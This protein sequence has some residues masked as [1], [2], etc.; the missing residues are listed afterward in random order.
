MSSSTW[1]QVLGGVAAGIALS[2]AA[3]ALAQLRPLVAPPASA[4]A[5][6]AGVEVFVL[7]ESR[8]AQPAVGPAEIETVALDGTK[9]RLIA[10]TD[11]PQ[12]VAPGGFARLHYRLAV[13]Y[14]VAAAQA[15][16]EQS[17]SAPLAARPATAETVVATSRGGS[18]AFLDR[19]YPYAPIYGVAGVGTAG[20]KLQVSFDFRLLGHDD[21]PRLDFAYTQ[22]IFWAVDR[23]SGPI[24]T[25]GYSPELFFDVPIDSSLIVGAGYRHDSNGGG[26]TDSVDVNRYFLRASKTFDLAHGW[27]LGVT[28]MAW[29]YFGSR[30]LAP[31]IDRYW[32]YSSLG[33][34]IGQRD[35][36]KVAVTARGNPATGKGGAEA[37]L[38]Y[39]IVRID[40]RLPRLYLFGQLFTGYG[41]ALV[42]YSRNASHARIG[43]ALTR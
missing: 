36:W 28:P 12:S 16:A 38:S 37:L 11:D 39:P 30:G 40:Q 43:I 31:D 5:A 10:G 2:R 8:T 13:S 24:R 4:D 29:G 35:G 25:Q 15:A 32:G 20:A 33:L 7:N 27:T 3:P 6:R 22:T 14:P 21:G 18:G 26:V 42:D 1:R 34:A 17:A 23:P 19:L 9:L 41:E